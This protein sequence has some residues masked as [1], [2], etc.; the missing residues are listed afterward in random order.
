[1][2][3]TI[4]LDVALIDHYDQLLGE[5]ELYITRTAKTQAVQTFARLQSIPGVGQILALV[6][7]YTSRGEELRFCKKLKA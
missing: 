5:V 4:A 3:E 7:L 1:V 2:H 6:L